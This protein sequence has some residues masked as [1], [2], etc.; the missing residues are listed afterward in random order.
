MVLAS[1]CDDYWKV[2]VL[3]EDLLYS[4]IVTALFPWNATTP[5]APWVVSIV[6]VIAE[7]LWSRNEFGRLVRA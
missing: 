6:V 7:V 3:I 5:P 1:V 4:T 2:R